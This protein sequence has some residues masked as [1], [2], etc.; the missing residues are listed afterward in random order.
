MPN[1]FAIFRQLLPATPLQVG[2]VTGIADGVATIELPGGGI[3]TARGDATVDQRVF[4]RAG[5]IEGAAPD[6]PAVEIEI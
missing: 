2:T 1:L 4:F 6:L 3:A 5:A